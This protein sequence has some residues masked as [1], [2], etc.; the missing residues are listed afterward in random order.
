MYKL[1]CICGS[2]GEHI[3]TIDG[4]TL[5]IRKVRILA[6]NSEELQKIKELLYSKHSSSIIAEIKKMNST[7][8]LHIYAA[9][10]NWNSGFEVPT[11]ILVNEN[12]DFGT[13]LLMFYRADGYRMFESTDAVFHSSLGEWKEFINNL[14]DRILDNSFHNK[15]F[16]FT[17]P[18][19]TKVQIFK[20]SKLNP[21]IPDIFLYKSPGDDI[22]IPVL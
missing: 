21:S 20:L 8:H 10:Y 3:G 19:L 1:K 7:L 9:N 18:P 22:E 14:H 12:C 16:S 4:V 17:P 2:L 6:M 15:K 13:G 5:L 11:A